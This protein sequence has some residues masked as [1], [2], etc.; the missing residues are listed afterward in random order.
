MA[1]MAWL[2]LLAVLFPSQTG[3]SCLPAAIYISV[4]KN[5]TN[6]N[7]KSYSIGV[8]IGNWDVSFLT[9]HLL[10]IIIEG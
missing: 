6:V 4:R 2:A 1:G 8:W 9:S 10:K 7:G 3:A 5:L